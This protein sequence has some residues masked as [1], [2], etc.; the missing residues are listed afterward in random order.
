MVKTLCFHCRGP[1]VQSLV[2]E[3]RP[4]RNYLFP[5]AYLGKTEDFFCLGC[6][7]LRCFLRALSSCSESGLLFVVV[8]RLLTVMASLVVGHGL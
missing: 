1:R 6:V 5:R 4:Q 8:L 2:T 7:G 3:I